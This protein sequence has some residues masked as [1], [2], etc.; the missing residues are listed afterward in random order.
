M[1]SIES[2]FVSIGL[3]IAALFGVHSQPASNLPVASPSVPTT[4]PRVIPPIVT[5]PIQSPV[6]QTQQGSSRPV[7]GEVSILV[8]S[9]VTSEDITS[10][11]TS[12]GLTLDDMS[13]YIFSQN[14]TPTYLACFSFSDSLA[15]TTV[16]YNDTPGLLG[17]VISTEDSIL[18]GGSSILEEA[19]FGDSAV[20]AGYL[21]NNCNYAVAF[22]AKANQQQAEAL[23]H[24]IDPKIVVQQF[25]SIAEIPSGSKW[26]IINVPAGDEQ[27]WITTLENNPLVISATQP[28]EMLP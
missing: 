1:K 19:F 13:A 18:H 8:H 24:A 7:S 9:S 16:L 11:L 2:F 3:A 25:I 26:V 21:S 27:K 15:T 10:M 23:L 5:P 17:Q 28:T 20:T 4:I 14:Q 22:N 12:Y 6:T